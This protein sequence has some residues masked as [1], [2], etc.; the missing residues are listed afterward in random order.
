MIKVNL[1]RDHAVRNRKKSFALPQLPREGLIFAA[2]IIIIAASM[3]L[4]T[5]QVL[6]QINQCQEMQKNLKIKEARLKELAKDAEKFEALTQMRQKRIAVIEK[7]KENQT[8]PVLLLN[9][10]IESL[11]N[12]SA[13]WLTSLTQ[14]SD[15][16]KIIGFTQKPE[17][18]PDFLSNLMISGIFKTV[19]LDIIE[20]QKEASRFS[21]SCVSIKKS[22]AE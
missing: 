10:I 18:I 2:V 22:Q 15:R 14:K 21:I 20:A 17:I 1:L 7:L 9:K 4:W 12:S 11:P 6:R 5:V 13:I 3:T 8:G 16:V 19:D